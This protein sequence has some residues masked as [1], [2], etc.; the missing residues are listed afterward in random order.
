MAEIFTNYHLRNTIALSIMLTCICSPNFFVVKIS[1][2]TAS[3]SGNIIRARLPN[4]IK[5]FGVK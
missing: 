3:I 5:K 2:F 1:K 4:G